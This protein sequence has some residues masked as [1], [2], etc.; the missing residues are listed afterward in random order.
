MSKKSLLLCILIALFSIALAGC[1]PPVEP[2]P[3]PDPTP[4]VVNDVLIFEVQAEE[5]Q[6]TPNEF[7]VPANQPVTFV[8][9]SIDDFH[10]FTV[11]RDEAD[12]ENLFNLQVLA[13]FTDEI[14][15]TFEETGDY[16]LYCINHEDEGMVGTI[17]VVEE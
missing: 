14:T 12:E 1:E 10:T 3:P 7:V 2:P 13:G 5:F 8:M 4:T 6:F 11:K 15:W 16:Y 17:T 9:T